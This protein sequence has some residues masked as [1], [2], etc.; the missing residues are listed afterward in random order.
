MN[1]DDFGIEFSR[2]CSFTSIAC[3]EE[4]PLGTV[5]RQI[6]EMARAYE[7]DGRVFLEQG[8]IVNGH[9][10]FAYGRGW[11]DAGN[12]MGFLNIPFDLPS[13]PLF[14]EK[15]PGSMIGKLTEKTERYAW[16]FSRACAALKPAPQD[17]TAM[18][19]LAIDI[20]IKSIEWFRIGTCF[21]SGGKYL[22][23]LAYYSYA[24][25]W[26]DA[27]LRAGLFQILT[28]PDLFTI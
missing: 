15:I 16:M 18:H 6:L 1:I 17:G 3:P 5:A 10:S 14:D 4:T 2:F 25:G 19:D 8:D 26:L 24:Y 11:L 13:L 22:N 7:K 28:A 20:R 9:A 21:I 27:G 12:D 23:A